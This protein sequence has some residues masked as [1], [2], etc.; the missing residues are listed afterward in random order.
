[1]TMELP[2]DGGVWGVFVAKTTH[3]FVYL[4]VVGTVP[5]ARA[6][7]E[8]I[9]QPGSVMGSNCGVKHHHHGQGRLEG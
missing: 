3:D 6:R 2:V 9:P 7:E 5:L 4:Q 8:P 1:M